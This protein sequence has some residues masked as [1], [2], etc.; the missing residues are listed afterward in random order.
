MKVLVVYNFSRTKLE[1]TAQD[2]KMIEVKHSREILNKFMHSILR[3]RYTYV[4]ITA[5]L[6]ETGEQFF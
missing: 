1:P 3:E 4:E 2:G 5:Y 6:T